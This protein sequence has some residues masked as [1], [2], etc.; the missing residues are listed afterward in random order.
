MLSRAVLRLTLRRWSCCP[1]KRRNPGTAYVYSYVD[2]VI[3]CAGKTLPMGHSAAKKDS[4]RNVSKIQT[5]RNL[6]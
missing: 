6:F 4:L 1:R 3:V 5:L 2:G